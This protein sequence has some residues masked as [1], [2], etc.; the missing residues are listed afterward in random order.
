MNLNQNLQLTQTQKLAI[1]TELKQSLSI[2]NMN[3]IELEEEVKREAE[4]NPIIEIDK[5]NEIDWEKYIKNIDNSYNYDNSSYHNE[6]E[7]YN[8]E[9]MVKHYDSLYDHLKFQIGLYKL[10][11]KEREVCEY[12]IDSMD[13]NGYLKLNIDE[14]INQINVEEDLIQKSISIVQQLEPSGVGARNL[15]ECLLI[16][17]GNMNIKDELLENIIKNDLELLALKKYKEISKKYKISLDECVQF[18]NK[19]QK[20][21]P[22]PG[23]K[24]SYIKNSYIVPDVIV[25]KIDNEYIIYTNEKDTYNIKINNFYK[26][27]L[28]NSQKDDQAKEFIKEKLN[29]AMNLIKNIENRKSTILKISKEILNQ[30]KDFFEK[31]SKYLRPLT[32]KD[33]A[34]NIGFHESTISRGVNGKYMLTPYGVFELKYFFSSGSYS[35]DEG[36][37]STSIKKFIEE[38]IKEENKKRPY[39]DDK[40]AYILEQK[41]IKIARRTIAKYRE[42]LNIPSSSKRKEY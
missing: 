27:V 39:S 31:G 2:L 33:I 30:Q 3:V 17:L 14:I 7:D 38:I 41:G 4:E 11:N 32:L 28:K 21:E 25:E 26:E 23:L 1:T 12:V 5:S 13:E 40:I 10:T 15:E 36:T 19:I 18:A 16:Q 34:E 20:L 37:A 24:Y 22:K 35:T 9:N 42:E 8:L 29:S 6:N